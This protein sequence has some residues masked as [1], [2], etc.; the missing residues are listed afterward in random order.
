MMHTHRL[1][2]VT[3]IDKVLLK[4]SIRNNLLSGLLE[5]HTQPII[6]GDQPNR[7]LLTYGRRAAVDRVSQYRMPCEITVMEAK[8]IV[9][10]RPYQQTSSVL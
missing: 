2:L 10:F 8:T 4:P 3:G 5:R 9:L 6:D 1:A 7:R